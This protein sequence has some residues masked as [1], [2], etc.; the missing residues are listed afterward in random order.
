MATAAGISATLESSL[1]K[2]R[3]EESA[4]RNHLEQ[5]LKVVDLKAMCKELRVKVCSAKGE[6]V[7][8]L[9]S[10]WQMGL[11]TDAEDSDLAGPSALTPEVQQ[12]LADPPPFESVRIWTKDLHKGMPLN[13]EYGR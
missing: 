13:W 2:F 9:L 10:Q 4:D 7:G 3:Y 11:F 6:L 12:Q 1:R 5:T 8:R